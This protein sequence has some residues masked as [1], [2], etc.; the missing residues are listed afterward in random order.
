MEPGDNVVVKCSNVV[1]NGVLWIVAADQTKATEDTIILQGV[2]AGIDKTIRIAKRKV[3]PTT[4]VYSGG[5]ELGPEMYER[6]ILETFNAYRDDDEPDPEPFDAAH[7]NRWVPIP[8]LGG[9]SIML[10]RRPDGAPREDLVLFPRINRFDLE[11][12]FHSRWNGDVIQ[13]LDAD[14]LGKCPQKQLWPFCAWCQRFHLP[15]EGPGSHR[16]SIKHE[17]FK[18]Q[19]LPFYGADRVRADIRNQMHMKRLW[20]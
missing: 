17:K 10:R 5:C 12:W 16:Q 18:N 4:V 20:L 13:L 19:H 11:L 3:F 6:T 9:N 7:L 2:I 15:H 14:S 1:Y 8:G